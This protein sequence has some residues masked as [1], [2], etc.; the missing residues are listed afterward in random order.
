[1]STTNTSLEQRIAALED[2]A[3][4]SELLARFCL[5]A[6]QRRWEELVELYTED[7]VFDVMGPVTGRA[8]ILEAVSHLP[9]VWGHWYHFVSNE[10]V[11]LD[12]DRA[13]AT[14]SFNAPYSMGGVSNNAFGRYDDELERVDG[15]W[16]FAARVLSF[17]VNA[18]MSEGMSTT[19]PDGLRRA[20]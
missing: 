4:I 17:A 15:E 8:A 20:D 9:E 2:R 12:G 1:M 14:S 10:I 16:K 5:Y 18:P 7:G 3:A 19:L 13:R 6:D 11:E